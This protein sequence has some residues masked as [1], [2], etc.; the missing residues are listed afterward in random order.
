LDNRQ[1]E[2]ADWL[3]TSLNTVNLE[4]AGDYQLGKAGVEVNKD[5]TD[6]RLKSVKEDSKEKE[7]EKDE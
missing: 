3:R 7:G 6:N 5:N 1:E 2:E 4:D